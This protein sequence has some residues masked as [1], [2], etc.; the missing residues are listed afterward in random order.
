M[1]IIPHAALLVVIIIITLPI[2][3]DLL[4]ALKK[5]TETQGSST[6]SNVPGRPVL[7]RWPTSCEASRFVLAET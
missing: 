4:V 7:F 1:F 6:S 3:V 2:L 5:K